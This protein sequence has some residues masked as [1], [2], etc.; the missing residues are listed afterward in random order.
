MSPKRST[1]LLEQPSSMTS[2][3]FQN[4]GLLGKQRGRLEKIS[5]DRRDKRIKEERR[6]DD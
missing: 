4:D 3:E 6:G 5:A 1:E 2:S